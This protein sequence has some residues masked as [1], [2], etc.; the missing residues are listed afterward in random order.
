MSSVSIFDGISENAR[1][2]MRDC[3]HPQ[4]KTFRA[5][6]VLLRFSEQPERV[7]VLLEGRARLSAFDAEGRCN[8]LEL[9][10]DDCVFGAAFQL[11]LENFEFVVTA[12]TSCHV[13]FLEYAHIVKR[14]ANACAHHSQ[15]V[16]NL[17]RMTAVKA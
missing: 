12:D 10:T 8:L 14:C 7:G 11:P 4:E 16:R 15:L 13:L 17:F 5:G 2:Q 1:L 3:F 9:L 6:D